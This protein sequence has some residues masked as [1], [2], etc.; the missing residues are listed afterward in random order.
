MKSLNVISL[1]LIIIGGLNWLVVGLFDYDAVSELFG[2][3]DEVGA[4]IVY[5]LVGVAAIYALA[6]VGKVSRDD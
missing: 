5:T 4:R 3:S 1:L 6:L 2:G